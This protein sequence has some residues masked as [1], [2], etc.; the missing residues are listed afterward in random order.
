M[1]VDTV[2]VTGQIG[3]GL[4]VTSLVLSNVTSISF[5]IASNVLRVVNVVGNTPKTT[6]FDLRTIA[7]VT[8]S[9]SSHIA[10]ITVST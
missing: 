4:T 8:Y 3:P 9:I 2:T 10:T 5:L 6:D 7:T 1:A